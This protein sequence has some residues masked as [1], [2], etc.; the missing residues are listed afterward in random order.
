MSWKRIDE[1]SKPRGTRGRR[2]CLEIKTVPPSPCPLNAVD[3]VM[4]AAS[5]LGFDVNN[6]SFILTSQNGS[7]SIVTV[8]HDGINYNVTV[9]QLASGDW[10]ISLVNQIQ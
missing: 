1:G 10:M 3:I 5:D 2:N 9:D 8:V 4:A 7:Q 6:D